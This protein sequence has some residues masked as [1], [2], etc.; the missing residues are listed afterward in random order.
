MAK[1]KVSGSAKKNIVTSTE[2]TET[3]SGKSRVETPD[4]GVKVTG[5]NAKNTFSAETEVVSV[6]KEATSA[7]RKKS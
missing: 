1:A 4:N 3:K 5:K 6:K 2:V 7:S